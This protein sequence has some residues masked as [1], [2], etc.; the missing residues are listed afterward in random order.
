MK[1]YELKYLNIDPT[2]SFRINSSEKI[3]TSILPKHVFIHSNEKTNFEKFYSY[4][5]HQ[6]NLPER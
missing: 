6:V 1:H 5:R 2:S 3:I 4:L